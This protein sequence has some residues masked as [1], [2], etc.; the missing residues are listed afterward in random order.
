VHAASIGAS[1]TRYLGGVLHVLGDAAS[2]ARP[3]ILVLLLLGLV[4]LRG[5]MGDRG[6]FLLAFVL[7]YGFVLTGLFLHSGYVSRRH[8]MPVI[9]LLLG[10]A[11]AGVPVFGYG[12]V[13]A[14]RR[15]ARRAGP[16]SPGLAL[17]VGLAVAL[18]LGIGKSI[19]PTRERAVAE[20]H[21]A[22]WLRDV[23]TASDRVAGTKQR[24][25]FYADMPFVHLPFDRHRTA[26]L[27]VLRR[28]DVRWLVLD[29]E[30]APIL[31]HATE[32]DPG[33]IRLAHRAHVDGYTVL[34]YELVPTRHEPTP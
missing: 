5:P 8:S 11:A 20:R 33:A 23:R 16:V 24:I 22:Q 1:A 34:V 31:E 12:L 17:G 21:A 19:R 29:E 26:L 10:Y 14:A 7:L 2:S 4:R 25:G 32:G 18:S 9:A 30:D 13:A 27:D 3:E 15:I 28:E 6:R